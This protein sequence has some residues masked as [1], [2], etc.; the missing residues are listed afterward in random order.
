MEDEVAAL[1]VDNGS[2]KSDK[3]AER[4]KE[5]CGKIFVKKIL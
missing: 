3:F 5:T 2:G 4:K 1:V